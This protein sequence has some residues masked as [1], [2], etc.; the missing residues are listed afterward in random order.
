MSATNG[1]ESASAKSSLPKMLDDID[2]STFA[3]ERDRIQ[4]LAAA[5]AL[6]SRLETPWDTVA[7]LCMTEPALGASLKMTVEQ[8]AKLAGCD[9]FLVGRILRHLVATNVIDEV[10]PGQYQ[11]TAFSTALLQPVIGEWVNYLYDAATPCF[12]KMPEYLGKSGYR[13]TTDPDDGVFQYT[14]GFHGDLFKY[15]QTHSREGQSF[16]NNM[17]GVMANQ[18]GMLD[19]YPYDALND[20]KPGDS[21]VPL[22]VDK[23]PHPHATAYNLTMM[24]KVS[25]FERTESMWKDLLG[26]AGFRAIKIWSSPVATQS[27]I[28]A[29]RA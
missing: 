15:Y 22:L 16:N 5:Y 8:L 11:Q 12:H 10:S 28:E 4:A 23:S 19:I 26:G 24:V 21:A 6:V 3:V 7:R 1:T 29:E 17:G 13:N 20:P 18:A 14:K 27:V 9:G 2:K 25:V